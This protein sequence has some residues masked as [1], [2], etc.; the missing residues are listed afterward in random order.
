MAVSVLWER[1]PIPQ[2][3]YKWVSAQSCDGSKKELGGSETFDFVRRNGRN[4]V[5]PFFFFGKLGVSKFISNIYN[6]H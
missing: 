6:F 2:A 4:L 5:D 1:L 3:K